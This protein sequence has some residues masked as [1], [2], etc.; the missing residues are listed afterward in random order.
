MTAMSQGLIEIGTRASFITLGAFGSAT[1]T[2]TVTHNS[3]N[4]ALYFEFYDPIG[5]PRSKLIEV[6]ANDPF[7]FTFQNTAIVPIECICVA[8]FQYFSPLDG[9]FIPS[10]EVVLT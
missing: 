10:S 4:P 5:T 7:T 1:D 6:I 2:G 3:E 8:I 9:G